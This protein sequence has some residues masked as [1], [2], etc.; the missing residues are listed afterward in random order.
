MIPTLVYLNPPKFALVRSYVYGVVL[1]DSLITFASFSARHLSYTSDIYHVEG[2]MNPLFYAW[3]SNVYTL[4]YVWNA[5]TFSLSISGVPY[6]GPWGLF[7]FNWLLPDEGGWRVGISLFSP[8]VATRR[9]A[10]PLQPPG[11]WN[12]MPYT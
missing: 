5:S 10:L 7:V 8:A 11:W 9:F 2:D 4:D 6:A 3:S 1:T 12:P